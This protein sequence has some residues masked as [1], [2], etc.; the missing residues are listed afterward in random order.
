MSFRLL[1]AIF[2]L[3]P[4]LGQ[5]A[6]THVMAGP[7]PKLFGTKETR[8]PNLKPFPKWTGML[9]RFFKKAGTVPGSCSSKTFNKCH[10]ERWQAF[11][12]QHRGQ[13][14]IRQLDAV[15]S[16]MNKTR[17]IVDPINWG[18]KDYW[19]TPGQFMAKYGDC[20]DYAI[21]KYLTLKRL[22]FDASKMRIVVLH[23]LNLRVAHAVLAVYTGGDIIILDNQIK[24]MVEANVIRHYKPIFSI[25]EEAWWL[26]RSPRRKRAAKRG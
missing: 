25:N 12:D 3:L 16:F 20:E 15:N 18:V 19:A 11:I 23:D 8:N 14:P 22:G 1:I 17:Y 7:V 5:T 26:H 2:V 13:D 21:A 4:V 6:T 10:A 9:D 24:K